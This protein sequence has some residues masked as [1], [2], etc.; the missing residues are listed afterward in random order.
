MVSVPEGMME[1][2]TQPLSLRDRI[3]ELNEDA[4]RVFEIVAESPRTVRGVLCGGYKARKRLRR[5]LLKSGWTES[6]INRAFR[7]LREFCLASLSIP[8]M[9]Y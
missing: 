2:V 3:V 1:D 9:G 6:R 7:E 8:E 5:Y 4:R